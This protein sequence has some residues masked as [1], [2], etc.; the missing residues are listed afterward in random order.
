MR[1]GWDMDELFRGGYLKSL[2]SK[3]SNSLVF[4]RFLEQVIKVIEVNS[5]QKKAAGSW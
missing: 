2:N 1:E 4:G 5:I 3:T